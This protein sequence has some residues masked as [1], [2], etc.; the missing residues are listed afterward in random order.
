MSRNALA[1][2]KREA[3]ET[4]DDPQFII[5][6][7]RDHLR[8][9]GVAIDNIVFDVEGAR[10]RVREAVLLSY[11]ESEERRDDIYGETDGETIWV[12]RGLS[13]YETVVTLLHE[14]MHDAVFIRRPTRSG[15][16]KG[17]S[18]D[19]EHEVIHTRLEF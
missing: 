1:R 7:F 11:A 18:C 12:L 15:Q 5:G 3:L 4:L 19:L 6:P 16:Q 17:L 13:P 8:K 14:A 10:R 9:R 2:A